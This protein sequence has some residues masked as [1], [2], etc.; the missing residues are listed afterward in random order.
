ML[1]RQPVDDGRLLWL[2]PSL[3]TVLLE[4]R[5]LAVAL[6]RERRRQADSGQGAAADGGDDGGD[7]DEDGMGA[8]NKV[9][10]ELRKVF[11][12]L[13][14]IKYVP[15]SRTSLGPAQRVAH[16]RGGWMRR[17]IPPVR[18]NLTDPTMKRHALFVANE[19]FVCSFRVRADTRP[20]RE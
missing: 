14:N 6:D 16:T 20:R 13:I 2:A 9:V 7:D 5:L 8:M 10:N 4:L 1:G 17:I 12:R 19:L 11:G 15:V 18:A 3:R